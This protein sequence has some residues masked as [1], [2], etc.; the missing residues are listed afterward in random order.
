MHEQ[1]RGDD[2]ACRR[3]MKAGA[4]P[5]DTTAASE[6]DSTPNP[7]VAFMRRATRPSRLSSIMATKM[8]VAACG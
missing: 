3:S 7:R 6:S 2:R 5:K 4:T 8:V 1:H